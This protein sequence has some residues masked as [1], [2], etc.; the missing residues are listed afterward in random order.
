MHFWPDDYEYSKRAKISMSF[1]RDDADKLT[2][3]NI[4]TVFL[5]SYLVI[6]Q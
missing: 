1:N 4:S 5:K 2:F 3:K 6:R